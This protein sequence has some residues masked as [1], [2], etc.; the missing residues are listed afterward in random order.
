MGLIEA[1]AWGLTGG[2][3]AGLIA[4][5]AAITARKFRWP[6]RHE[7]W[8]RLTVVAMGLV[9]G[10]AVAGAAHGQL[11]GEL[12]ALIMGASA[13]SVIRGMLNRVEVV[14]AKPEAGD[15]DGSQR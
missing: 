7:R 5:S 1:G 2:M 15:R 3:V 4:L 13:P 9:V 8:P 6:R 10:A 12:P 11:A 14:E